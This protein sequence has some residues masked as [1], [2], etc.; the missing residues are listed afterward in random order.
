MDAQ[1]ERRL[2]KSHATV[3]L[4]QRTVC[5]TYVWVGISRVVYRMQSITQEVQGNNAI[6]FYMCGVAGTVLMRFDRLLNMAWGRE[7]RLKARDHWRS[8]LSRGSR[9]KS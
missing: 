5:S 6:I 3:K 1:S 4:V 7:S 9:V 2:S 8:K